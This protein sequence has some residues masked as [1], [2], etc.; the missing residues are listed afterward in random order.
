MNESIN[1]R[2]EF[3]ANINLFKL[4]IIFLNQECYISG[5]IFSLW[6]TCFLI[7]HDFLKSLPGSYVTQWFVHFYC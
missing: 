5:I 6:G 4:L 3:L 7:N 2:L 1:F